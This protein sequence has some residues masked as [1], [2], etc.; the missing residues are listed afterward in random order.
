MLKFLL[1][2]IARLSWVAIFLLIL[3]TLIN[4][5]GCSNSSKSFNSIDV[6]GAD[7]GKKLILTDINSNKVDLSKF[8]GK[9]VTLFF[10]FLSCPDFCP[11]HLNKMVYLK[12]S[13]NNRKKNLVVIFVSVDPE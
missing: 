3:A 9:V 12:E 10:G 11:N 5:L 8:Q 7:W 1:K 2:S 13:L 6:T 4:F